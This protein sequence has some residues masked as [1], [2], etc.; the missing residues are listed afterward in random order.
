MS[1]PSVS[2][3]PPVSETIRLAGLGGDAA[4]LTEGD[5][6]PRVFLDRLL[7]S[8]RYGEA[9]RY[10]AF[11]LPKREAVWWAARCASLAPGASS[12]GDT[13]PQARAMTAAELWAADPSEANRR[14]AGVAGEATMGTPAGCAAL[15]AFWSG[16]SLA[17]EGLPEVPPADDLT[18]RGVAAAV[19]LAGVVAS[20][21]NAPERYRRFQEIGLAVAE[22]IDRWSDSDS[23][24]VSAS[25]SAPSANPKASPPNVSPRPSSAT[26]FRDTWE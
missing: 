18:A 11:A 9:A 16:G 7:E 3:L 25:I 6:S 15:A 24:R 14:G 8:E 5:P 4:K 12:L 22:G 19:M 10:L 17:P 20:P 23:P 1:R 26:R 13:D 21:E 2:P